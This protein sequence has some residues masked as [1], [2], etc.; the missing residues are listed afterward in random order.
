[1]YV[2]FW[3]GLPAVLHSE[4]TE[5][6]MSNVSIKKKKINKKEEASTVFASDGHFSLGLLSL[7]QSHSQTKLSSSFIQAHTQIST[8][9]NRVARI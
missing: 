5:E 3:F 7:P 6:P 1:M 4:V 8:T 2:H 9:T